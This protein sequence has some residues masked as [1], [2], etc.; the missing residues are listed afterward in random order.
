MEPITLLHELEIERRESP[1]HRHLVEARRARSAARRARL[2]S[3][4]RATLPI[5]PAATRTPEPCGC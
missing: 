5:A 3:L 1:A 2:T 4:V